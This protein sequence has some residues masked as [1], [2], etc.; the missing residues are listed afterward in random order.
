[1][2]AHACLDAAKALNMATEIR[3]RASTL[4]EE[5]A[6]LRNMAQAF[7]A[8][9]DK[10]EDIDSIQPRFQEA[11]SPRLSRIAGAVLKA[12]AERADF[13]PCDVF[14]EPGWN[15]LLELFTAREQEQRIAVTS[16]CIAS[17]AP[18]TTALRWVDK[19]VAS[20][21]VVLKPSTSDGRVIYVE[22]S[23]NG[24]LSMQR[25]FRT[26]LKGI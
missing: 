10:T 12:R 15:M 14:G 18:T 13:L 9:F 1:M 16:L 17:L 5:A 11:D 3:D 21:L 22:L 24:F 8:S 20:D 23:R 26:A 2:N 6:R 4:E 19:L 7:D 25:Y